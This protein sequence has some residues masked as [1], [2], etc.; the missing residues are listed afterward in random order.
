MGIYV[1]QLGYLPNTR[2]IAAATFPC[3]FKIMDTVKKQIVLKALPLI[4]EWMKAPGI[5]CTN[6]IFPL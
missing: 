2:K 3:N 6:W 4:R 5:I 1:N